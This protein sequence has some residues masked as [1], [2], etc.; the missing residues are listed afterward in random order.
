M[1]KLLKTIEIYTLSLGVDTLAMIAYICL[2][3]I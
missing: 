3:M 1:K 2:Y